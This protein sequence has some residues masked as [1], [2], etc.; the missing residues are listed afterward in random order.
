[1]P[2]VEYRG[3]NTQHQYYS[4]KKVVRELNHTTTFQSELCFWQKTFPTHLLY[5]RLTN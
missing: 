4:I 5:H 3:H 2:V 1:M